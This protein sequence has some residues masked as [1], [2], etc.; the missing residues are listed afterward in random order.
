MLLTDPALI[1]SA[2]L[3]IAWI[4]VSAS[5]HKLKSIAQMV[6]IVNNYRVMPFTVSGSFVIAVA[7]VEMIVALLLVVPGSR[8]LGALLSAILLFIYAAAIG[9]NLV[10]GRVDFNCGCSGQSARK[11]IDSSLVWR[12][13]VL[14][15]VALYSVLPPTERALGLVDYAAMMLTTVLLILAYH[16][17]E[18]LV[19]NRQLLLTF[20]N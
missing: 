9:I 20:K 13:T 18:Q 14:I 16:T 19:I 2:S 17:V 10:R 5:W 3:F 15:A 1:T 11:N 6:S 7:G 4:F 12:N 8:Q